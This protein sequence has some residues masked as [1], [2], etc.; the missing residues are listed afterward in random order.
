V[1][2]KT[3]HLFFWGWATYNDIFPKT[4]QHISMFCIELTEV[5]GQLT[6]GTGYQFLWSLC[7]HHNCVDDECRGEPY[8]TPTKIWK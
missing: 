2:D 4:P 3:A 5:R 1:K 6:P 7:G 8:G